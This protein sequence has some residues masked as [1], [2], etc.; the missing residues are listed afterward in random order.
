MLRS[1]IIIY[2]VHALL[3]RYNC[4]SEMHVIRFIF[5]VHL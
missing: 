4:C 3:H 1:H 5:E 2:Y